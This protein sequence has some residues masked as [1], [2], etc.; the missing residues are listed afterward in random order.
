MH[1]WKDF[2]AL[3]TKYPFKSSLFTATY[4]LLFV[5]S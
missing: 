1:Q 4:S 5:N 2:Q 3:I